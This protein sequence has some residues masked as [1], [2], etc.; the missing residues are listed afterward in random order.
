MKNPVLV[1]VFES[2]DRLQD[3][4]LDV[5]GR[6]DDGR[7]LIMKDSSTT[8]VFILKDQWWLMIW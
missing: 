1:Q 7:V 8:I 3:V 2:P 4:G 6:Q 5:S